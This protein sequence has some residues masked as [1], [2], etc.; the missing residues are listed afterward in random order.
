MLIARAGAFVL[1]MSAMTSATTG[2]AASARALADALERAETV[3]RI[4]DEVDKTGDTASLSKA[5]DLAACVI[6]QPEEKA[7]AAAWDILLMARLRVLA[8]C[9][10]ARDHS[11]DPTKPANCTMSVSPPLWAAQAG[12]QMIISGMDPKHV[13]DPE[14]R[15]QYE[16]D[17]AEN[18]RKKARH[19]RERELQN[20]ADRGIADAQKLIDLYPDG[21]PERERLIETS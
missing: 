17:I 4:L 8:K 12:H 5:Y 7:A 3:R 21:A 11:Y 14:A 6:P 20:V 10:R 16:A 9:Y 15:R 1:V 2:A 19:R 18:D 13:R